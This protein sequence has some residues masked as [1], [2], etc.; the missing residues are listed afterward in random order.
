[1]QRLFTDY[2]AEY[3][4]YALAQR[5]T[6]DHIPCPSAGDPQRNP[7]RCGIARS[8][9]A[10]RAI[11]TNPR[12]TGHQVWN[13]QHKQET[14]IDV[15][16]VG[17]GRTTAPRRNPEDQW[18]YSERPAH[19]ALISREIFDAVQGRLASRGPASTG[20][21]VLR[22]RHPYAL[23]G[24][25]FHARCERHMQGN[26]THGRAHYRCRFPAEYALANHLEHP[27]N[28]LLREDAVLPTLDAWLAQAFVLDHLAASLAALAQDQPATDPV[29]RSL[30][31]R[32]PPATARS[33][34]TASPWK[35]EPTP[36]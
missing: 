6:D 32:S 10:V 36:P 18:I 26:W 2:L 35:P 22:T 5:L 4:I 34:G 24:W 30:A 31:A 28:V 12:Y 19:P 8:K 27:L 9:S 3:G 16:D 14:L 33:S 1:M 20:R 17:L 7:D 21:T 13:R 29:P 11:L 23:K 15:N 25:S